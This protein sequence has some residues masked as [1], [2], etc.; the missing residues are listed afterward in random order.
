MAKVQQVLVWPASVHEVVE[1]NE[2]PYK[3]LDAKAGLVARAAWRLLEWLGVLSP[4]M[5]TVRRW[6]Y[7]PSE[8]RALHEAM[9]EAADHDLRNVADGKAVFIIGGATFSE[10]TN[11]PAFRDNMRFVTGSFGIND[12]YHGRRMCDIPVH[13]VPRMVGLALVPAVIVERQK[14]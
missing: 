4:Y 8:Q 5:E 7:V 14:A 9:L 12:P 6:D 11:A 1:R 3:L 10:L 13:V 2:T